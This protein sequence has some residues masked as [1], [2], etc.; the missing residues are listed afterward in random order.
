[1][2]KPSQGV[3]QHFARRTE[4]RA[5]LHPGDAG[6]ID[7]VAARDI[8]KCLNVDAG[9]TL[10]V[11]GERFSPTPQPLQEKVRGPDTGRTH[12]GQFVKQP[13]HIL[14]AEVVSGHEVAGTA[15]AFLCC[16]DVRA[17]NVPHV[18]HA[19]VQ[20]ARISLQ[21]PTEGAHRWCQPGVQRAEN[22]ARVHRSARTLLR[23]ETDLGWSR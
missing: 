22:S 8:L 13:G 19:D 10:F 4:P 3:H 15:S 1:M 6:V 14:R 12:T 21:K 9:I 11:T 2:E 17:R 18:C 23:I 7:R 20:E 5:Q 16:Q